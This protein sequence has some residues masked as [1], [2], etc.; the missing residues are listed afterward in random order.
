MMKKW[1]KYLCALILGVIIC[2]V[3]YLGVKKG[4]SGIKEREVIVEKP[5]YIEDLKKI[6]A[7][8]F[9]IQE[10][11]AEI[12]ALKEK[13][14]EIKEVVIYEK[15]RIDTLSP[16]SNVLLLREYLDVY[17]DTPC[18]TF[19][20]LTS[21]TLTLLDTGNVKAIN[22]VFLDYFADEE[23]LFDYGLII[24]TDSLTRISLDSIINIE[25]GIRGDLETTLTRERKKGQI[26]KSIGIGASIGA[27]ILGVLCYGRYSN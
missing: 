7:L 5:V 8:E 10:R 6:H 11:D 15:A 16:D 12:R 2:I 26:W 25:R 24:E 22:H 19:P 17:T 4:A 23:L 18:T 21:D 14:K 20:F 13:A 27:V 3:F 9:T 1:V